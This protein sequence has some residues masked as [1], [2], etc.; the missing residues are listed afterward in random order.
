MKYYLMGREMMIVFK[1]KFDV[2]IKPV[3]GAGNTILATNI[4]QATQKSLIDTYGLSN[5]PLTQ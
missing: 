2:T 4:K 5:L 1:E 3:L